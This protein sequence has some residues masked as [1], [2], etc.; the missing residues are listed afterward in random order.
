MYPGTRPERG[1]VLGRKPKKQKIMG[2][3]ALITGATSGIGHA[4]ALRLARNGYDVILTGRRQDR[5]EHLKGVIRQETQ[6]EVIP[7]CFDIRDKRAVA[8]AL[9]S[10]EPRF[11][12]VDVLVNN[13]G[14]AAGLEHIDE[15]SLEDWERMID[16]NVK[17]LLYVTRI[18][19]GWMTSRS[20]GHIINMGSV[21]GVQ[22]YENGNVYCA[23]KHAVHALSEGMRIDLL[24]HGIKV[25]EIRPGMVETEFSTVRFHGDKER[26]DQ[27]YKGVT[28][29]YG[30]DIASVV[31]WL[32]S[33]PPHMNVTEVQVMPTQQADAFYTY[34]KQ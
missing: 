7:L 18:V 27:V 21:A 3:T 2:K 23:T 4:T 34:R 9:E 17:G 22:T 12:A 33:L 20:S 25:S 28:P 14:L 13:A 24:R 32:V 1:Y 8:E 6:A 10:L 19:S 26:A 29:L 11:R 15:G 30:D 31:E 16:T 5:L